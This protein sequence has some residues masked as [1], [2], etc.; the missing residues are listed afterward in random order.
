MLSRQH[1]PAHQQRGLVCRGE[2]GAGGGI[3]DANVALEVVQGCKLS[4]ASMLVA[5]H[6]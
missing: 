1:L 3:A 4:H 6:Y 5:A 2:P